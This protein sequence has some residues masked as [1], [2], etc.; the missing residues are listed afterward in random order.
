MITLEKALKAINAAVKKADELKEKV[1]VTVVDNY[2]VM[3]ASQKMDGALIIS[4]KYAMAKAYTSAVLRLATADIAKYA[5]P[6]Q[7]Y[8]GT[9]SAF[10][11]ELMVIAGGIP[12]SENDQVVGAI[13]VGGSADVNKDVTCAQAGLG[14]L[15]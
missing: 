3:V 7:P 14:A 6:G 4:P 13:G 10:D 8:Y 11:G 9:T 12:V 15:E 2:G 1:T 5:T